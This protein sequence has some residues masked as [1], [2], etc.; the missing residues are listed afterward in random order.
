MVQTNT[1]ILNLGNVINIKMTSN[2]LKSKVDALIELISLGSVESPDKYIQQ[3]DLG[4]ELA[5]FRINLE[6]IG[7]SGLASHSQSPNM[8]CLG[9]SPITSS[10]KDFTSETYKILIKQA[11]KPAKLNF[12]HQDHP[13]SD[14]SSDNPMH[15]MAPSMK[16]SKLN[17]CTPTFPAKPEDEISWEKIV[18]EKPVPANQNDFSDF[19]DFSNFPKRQNCGNLLFNIET[20]NFSSSSFKLQDS[21]PP[22]PLLPSDVQEYPEMKIEPMVNF[23]N[24]NMKESTKRSR[25]GKDS[26]EDRDKSDFT[27]LSMQLSESIIQSFEK[28]NETI[29]LSDSILWN[30]QSEKVKE[31]VEND[32]KRRGSSNLIV[33]SV[34]RLSFHGNLRQ[35]LSV[36]PMMKN[37]KSNK[38][39]RPVNRIGLRFKSKSKDVGHF[40]STQEYKTET[41]IKEKGFH[42][43][44][45]KLKE[46]S[47][48]LRPKVQINP[49]LSDWNKSTL[50]TF[51]NVDMKIQK[52]SSSIKALLTKVVK[53]RV[54]I[55]K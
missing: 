24:E 1:N 12:I 35:G 29:V 51:F 40:A 6:E 13:E 42:A 41:K 53:K 25:E 9:I 10:T 54:K 19:S 48:K 23:L 17:Q 11:K 21:P 16:N 31:E 52:D 28:N 49:Y 46:I 44:L 55:M 30:A 34:K 27:N 33:K 3:V 7:N 4:S 37:T 18:L 14:D 8:S 50:K 47:S 36:T 45:P 43:K 5:S 39:L 22:T 38:D 20:N 32:T 15:L 2:T 26:R